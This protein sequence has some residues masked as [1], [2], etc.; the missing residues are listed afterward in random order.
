MRSN[1]PESGFSLIELAIVC[2]VIGLMLAMG[3]PAYH[4]LSQDQSLRGA[5][6]AIV[7]Q[8]T[9]ARA[10][11]MATGT[12]RTVNFDSSTNPPRIVVLA[13]TTAR[14]WSLPKGITFSNATSFA[15]TS[16]GRATTSQYI[17][18]QNLKANR[19][20][21]SVLTSGLVLLR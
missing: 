12:T 5:A 2:T 3:I 14:T 17:V 20:T 21:V 4:S 9:L 11:A 7:G 13:G 8:I 15:M 16:D 10:S 19:D 1:G 6:Q 18:L